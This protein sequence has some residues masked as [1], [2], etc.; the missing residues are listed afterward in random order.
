MSINERL[1]RKS[2]DVQRSRKNVAMN[3][4]SRSAQT[5]DINKELTNHQSGGWFLRLRET[6]HVVE[7][8]F[9]RICKHVGYVGDHGSDVVVSGAQ[10]HGVHMQFQHAI[11]QTSV[12]FDVSPL[13]PCATCRYAV[14]TYLNVLR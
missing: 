4:L 7:A 6:S 1:C 10:M 2:L 14:S 11:A 12:G 5:N 8:T 3:E 9:R 13:P